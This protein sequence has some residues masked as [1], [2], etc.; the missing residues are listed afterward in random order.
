MTWFIYLLGLFLYALLKICLVSICPPDLDDSACTLKSPKLSFLC[1]MIS[2]KALLTFCRKSDT[3][4]RPICFLS[5]FL[6]A[7]P[8]IAKLIQI[9]QVCVNFF[10]MANLSQLFFSKSS[11]LNGS[12]SSKV[13]IAYCFLV[14]GFKRVR[15]E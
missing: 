6:S 12:T 1:T 3:P 11:V 7:I 10:R 5:P 15:E 4:S 8:M 9:H 2:I 13:V 14:I